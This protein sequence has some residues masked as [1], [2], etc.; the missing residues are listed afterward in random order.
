M[1]WVCTTPPR[2]SGVCVVYMSTFVHKRNAGGVSA[3]N[4]KLE[5]EDPLLS[6]QHPVRKH[7][8]FLMKYN[9]RHRQLDKTF[10]YCAPDCHLISS[11]SD[12]RLICNKSNLL[13][14]LRRHHTNMAI[15]AARK[16][17]A[18]YK[19]CFLHSFSGYLLLICYFH[20]QKILS[21][22]YKNVKQINLH[23]NFLEELQ[24]KKISLYY[25]VSI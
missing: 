25:T 17:W 14:P 22:F 9:N 7:F 3:I 21:L 15:A 4:K 5:L 2:A 13:S 19:H 8:S 1:I 12:N 18:E 20:D 10:V 23:I 11:F 6:L 16:I 24:S